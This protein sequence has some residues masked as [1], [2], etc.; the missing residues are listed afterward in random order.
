MLGSSVFHFSSKIYNSTTNFL[1]YVHV[2]DFAQTNKSKIIMH[3]AYPF[4]YKKRMLMGNKINCHQI[5][6][7][8]IILVVTF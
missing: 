6:Q 1:A 3:Y 5:A 7:T 4:S 8:D 2:R